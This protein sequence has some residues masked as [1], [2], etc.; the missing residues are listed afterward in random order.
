LAGLTYRLQQLDPQTVADALGGKPT[1]SLRSLRKVTGAIEEANR[2]F[3]AATGETGKRHQANFDEMKAKYQ[4]QSAGKSAEEG[5][6]VLSALRAEYDAKAA[7]VNRS[8][9]AKPREKVTVS[10]GEEDFDKVLMPL[11]ELTAASWA[12]AEGKNS[13]KYFLEVADAL[14]GKTEPTTEPTTDQQENGTEE[15]K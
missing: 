5:Q 1:K 6:Q 9:T 14:E 2:E 4:E 10:L 13:Q 3:M 8:S 12:D 15:K 11:F 7:E